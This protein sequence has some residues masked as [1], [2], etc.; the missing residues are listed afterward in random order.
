M[1]EHDISKVRRLGRDAMKFGTISSKSRAVLASYDLMVVQPYHSSTF[2]L[3][4]VRSSETSMSF[5]RSQLL[6][7]WTFPSPDIH[8]NRKHD[9]SETGSV[10]TLK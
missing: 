9:V 10:S 8:E 6:G 5:Y 7:F 2:K 4:A 1:N 3:D